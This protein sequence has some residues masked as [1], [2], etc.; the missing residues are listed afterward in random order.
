MKTKTAARIALAI[1]CLFLATSC[2]GID[3]GSGEDDGSKK[4]ESTR[5]TCGVGGKSRK[6]SFI[7]KLARKDETSRW[8]L[9]RI[10]VFKDTGGSPVENLPKYCGDKNKGLEFQVPVAPNW[11]KIKLALEPGEYILRLGYV[12]ANSEPAFLSPKVLTLPTDGL[13][14][15][16]VIL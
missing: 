16:L 4:T 10:E 15:P 13:E 6:T 9:V 1:L 8:K 14:L 7:M 3:K 11:I 2:V 12:D 5:C